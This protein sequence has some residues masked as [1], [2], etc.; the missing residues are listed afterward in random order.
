M[1]TK[2]SVSPARRSS[3]LSYHRALGHALLL[4]KKFPE[5]QQEFLA[6][7]RLKRDSPDT[8]VDLA[9]AASENKNYELTVRALNGRATLNADMPALCFFW[10]ASAYD[11]LGDW[12]QASADYH[13]FLDSA[14]GKFPDQ[15]WQARHRLVTIEHKK[16]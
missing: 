9:F 7:V 4:Q 13:S 16:R 14:N 8:Y 1:S 12:K 2:S 5:A 10:R 6:A 3:T 11:H 15:E